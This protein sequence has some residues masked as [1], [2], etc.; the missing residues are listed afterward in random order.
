MK[1]IFTL[2]KKLKSNTENVDVNRIKSGLLEENRIDT[3]HVKI[4]K[5]ER[6][7]KYL[8]EINECMLVSTIF[9]HGKLKSG[10]IIELNHCYKDI[11]Y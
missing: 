4:E 5:I 6:I 10:M 9:R 2:G 3:L 11:Y 8:Y 7:S 1:Q